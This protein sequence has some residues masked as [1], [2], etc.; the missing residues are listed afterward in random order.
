M[1]RI[2][3][4]ER[5]AFA[6]PTPP[7]IFLS[8]V[9]VPKE[10]LVGKRG[11]RLLPSSWPFFD[12]SRAYVAGPWGGDLR[13]G[14]LDQA[15]THIRSRETVSAGKSVH[16]N[17]PSSKSPKWPPRWNWPEPLP[18]KACTLLDQGKG[19]TNTTAMAKM[20]AG[21][22]AVEVVDEALQLHGGYGYFNDQDIERFYRAAKVLEIY[23]GAKE[24]EKNDHRQETS[25]GK[26]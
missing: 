17:P 24:V 21:R 16:F 2:H 20:F 19:N 3:C 7:N 4:T 22:T 15:L 13:R 12:R 25:S 9:R 6:H 1:K 23:E 18:H 11:E 5:W 10:N 8:D 26:L 14:A